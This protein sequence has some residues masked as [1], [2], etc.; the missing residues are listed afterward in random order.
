MPTLLLQPQLVWPPLALPPSPLYS[1]SIS[2]SPFS[3]QNGLFFQFMQ[4]NVVFNIRASAYVFSFSSNS[5]SHHRHLLPLT[6]YSLL[7]HPSHHSLWNAFLDLCTGVLC[8]PAPFFFFTVVVLPLFVWSLNIWLTTI[9]KKRK[10]LWAKT[11]FLI[12]IPEYGCSV[13]INRLNEEMNKLNL[14]DLFHIHS[15]YYQQNIFR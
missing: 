9:I 5:P 15:H 12:L 1:P 14:A 3:S 2:P 4:L 11:D 6:L 13:N 8:I 10:L 7:A